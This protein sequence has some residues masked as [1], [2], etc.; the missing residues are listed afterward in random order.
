MGIP[1][2]EINES[3]VKKPIETMQDREFK[4]L[5]I[6]FITGKNKKQ[7]PLPE[8]ITDFKQKTQHDNSQK[9]QFIEDNTNVFKKL[10]QY[11]YKDEVEKNTITKSFEKLILITDQLLQSKDSEAAYN[12]II[13]KELTTTNPIKDTNAVLLNALQLYP[14]KKITKYDDIENV[15]PE[16]MDENIQ[17]A[18]DI[19]VQ[20]FGA[21][22][23][24]LKEILKTFGL[25][26]KETKGGTNNQLLV[27][28][29]TEGNEILNN[30]IYGPGED[31]VDPEEVEVK[32]G[33]ATVAKSLAD[34][35]AAAVANLAEFTEGSS[36]S[37]G[38]ANK[39]PKERADRFFTRV[40]DYLSIKKPTDNDNKKIETGLQFMSNYENKQTEMSTR[41]LNTLRQKFTSKCKETPLTNDKVI[42]MIIAGYEYFT[43]LRNIEQHIDGTTTVMR[44]IKENVPPELKIIIDIGY[45]HQNYGNV[46]TEIRDIFSAIQKIK[47]KPDNIKY[48][49][50]SLETFKKY[51]IGQ[52][53]LLQANHTFTKILL[54]N[55]LV[56][57][58]IV[59]Y[60]HYKSPDDA[61]L[62]IL[63]KFRIYEEKSYTNL[64]NHIV[65]FKETELTVP[66]PPQE[67][68]K[69]IDD[70]I[71][72]QKD[73]KTLNDTNLGINYLL[74]VKK[75]LWR[76]SPEN[77]LNY[78]INHIKYNIINNKKIDTELEKE[79][80]I[81]TETSTEFKALINR[82]PTENR[83]TIVGRIIDATS[84]TIDNEYYNNAIEKINF[85][86]QIRTIAIN[87]LNINGF[88]NLLNTDEKFH[89]HEI[90]S[91][92]YDGAL[93]RL[94]K[95]ALSI[96]AKTVFGYYKES[97]YND[98]DKT[99]EYL[100]LLLKN[101]S[102]FD[103]NFKQ[104]DSTSSCENKMI[105]AY[106]Y[107]SEKILNPPFVPLKNI[108]DVKT[109][110]TA[111]INTI[112]TLQIPSDEVKVGG[113]K[114]HPVNLNNVILQDRIHF[115]LLLF[116]IRSISIFGV[117]VATYN[118]YIK[119][120][121]HTT[122]LYFTIYTILLLFANTTGLFYYLNTDA[123]DGRGLLRI[124]LQL[125]CIC[126]IL[127]VPYIV[128]NSEET[129]RY[130]SLYIFVLAIIVTL[131]V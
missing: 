98:C 115:I 99:I 75:E 28:Y 22:S 39:P 6:Y 114:K 107:Y 24:K 113:N 122:L 56:K 67:P 84:D 19:I 58:I 53:P 89:I 77:V 17:K 30:I 35:F 88:F 12:A 23:D 111:N 110:I 81:F 103:N 15:E 131:V 45:L 120:I 106:N 101:A 37:F 55:I 57:T 128:K 119:T 49:D 20:N 79:L 108:E 125:T 87:S 43:K 5:L 73:I 29:L 109:N 59:L 130:Y 72:I 97:E 31:V 13:K 2:A 64:I 63:R 46:D 33:E 94:N 48:G 3:F 76:A 93:Y 80:K 47:P 95:I 118:G 18:Y 8:V 44:A 54:Q 90:S 9:S 69:T 91:K 41:E 11:S 42:K 50:D 70:L 68:G 121:S 74:F 10:I 123:E 112:L 36:S 82:I 65:Y 102:F 129:V 127:P 16:A 66:N 96:N 38:L 78:F 52:Q 34:N 86:I 7:K 26:L 27:G 92:M 21:N 116:I 104:T 71:K 100:E 62:A 117:E 61:T 85:F 126:S 83:I 60:I 1:F 51:V 14:R 124:I 32:V 4:K 40:Y 105:A 25:K